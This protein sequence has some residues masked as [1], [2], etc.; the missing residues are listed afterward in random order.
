[1]PA[2]V[3]ELTPADRAAWEPLWKGY[4]TFYKTDIPSATTDVTW[5][6]FHDPAELMWAFGAFD[7]GRMVGIV[8]AIEHRSCWTVGNYI[9]LQDLFVDPQVRGTGA[10]RVLIE[11][12]YALAKER[13]ASRVHWL[14]HETNSH[15]MLLYDRIADKSGFIQ[16]RRI[17]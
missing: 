4:Q 8:H 12:V 9:Y 16:Y 17:I 3:R 2:T 11:R 10:G 14:T 5:A 15:A 6:R 13:G 7:G 1:M